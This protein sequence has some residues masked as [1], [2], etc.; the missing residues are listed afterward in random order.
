MEGYEGYVESEGTR[1][2]IIESIMQECGLD[3]EYGE[4]CLSFIKKNQEILSGDEFFQYSR[5][6]EHEVEGVSEFISEEGK[7]Y[8]SLKKSTIFLV[9]LYV[10]YRT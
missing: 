5:L 2:K 1:S 4:Q 8:I 3:R 6:E 10:R 9:V 7:Y